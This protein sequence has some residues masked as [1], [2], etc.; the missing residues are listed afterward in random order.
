MGTFLKFQR[1]VTPS[2]SS[3]PANQPLE[4]GRGDGAFT[5]DF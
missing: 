1:V 5:L 4:R 3:T 2:A